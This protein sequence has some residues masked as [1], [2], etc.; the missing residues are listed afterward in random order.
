MHPATTAILIYIA[1][2][3]VFAFAIFAYDKSLAGRSG[4]RRISERTL[5]LA[6]LI[7]GSPAALLAMR[8]FR[9]KTLKRSFRIRMFWIVVIQLT[10]AIA[11]IAWIAWRR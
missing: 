7:G 1:A 10:L 9:H 5:F 3:N 8:M 2:V 11:W 6:A 4:K